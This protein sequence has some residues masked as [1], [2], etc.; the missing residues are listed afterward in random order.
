M[1]RSY[2]KAIWK[3]KSFGNNLYNRITR[4][5]I[6]NSVKNNLLLND[7]DEFEVVDRKN[8]IN[9]YTRC[10]QIVDY[11]YHK[12]LNYGRLKRDKFDESTIEYKNKLRRK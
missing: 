10:D 6:N 2:K 4:R 5:S 7:L 11:E 1:S 12:S 9:N 3:E 8:V